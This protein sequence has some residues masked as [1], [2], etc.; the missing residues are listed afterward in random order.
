MPLNE[1]ILWFTLLK[2][3]QRSYF[4]FEIV[5]HTLSVPIDVEVGCDMWHSDIEI[6][7]SQPVNIDNSPTNII[8]QAVGKFKATFAAH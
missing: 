1:G 3:K 7:Q 2:F 8:A 6:T 5:N 4:F